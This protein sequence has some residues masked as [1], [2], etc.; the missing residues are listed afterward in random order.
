VTLE[1]TRRE[2]FNVSRALAA[3][4]RTLVLQGPDGEARVPATIAA[5]LT[6]LESGDLAGALE[7]LAVR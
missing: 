1:A 7:P 5:T 2:G 3:R 6:R 4:L